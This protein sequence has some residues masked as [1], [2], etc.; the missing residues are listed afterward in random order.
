M[1]NKQEQR[2]EETKK[3]ILE[4]A[5]N[6]F[7]KKGYD[8]VTIR[9][10]AKEAGCS[11]TTIYLY[12]KDKEALLHQLSMP[13]L[14]ELHIQLKQIS[15]MDTLTAEVKLKEISREYI[16]FCLKNRNM[17]DVFF[18]AK[19][20]R[21]D[22]EPELEIN[23][24]RVEIFEMMKLVIQQC[25]SIPNDEQLLAFSRIYY[26]NLNGILITYSYQ[27]E[28]LD[29]LM[30]RLTPTFDLAIEILVLGFREKLK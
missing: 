9:E 13:S 22:E 11:H 2:S 21:V 6:L 14:Q 24:F 25:L 30:E 5:G 10:I 16:H 29:I 19:S 3:Q 20:S 15:D 26:Y 18:N 4:S 27:H 8:S 12:F 7:A 28:P 23:K 1:K 17:Y